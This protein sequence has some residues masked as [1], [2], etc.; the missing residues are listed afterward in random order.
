MQLLPDDQ[1]DFLDCRDK[2]CAFDKVVAK[3]AK[4]IG[5]CKVWGKWIVILEQSGSKTD[6]ILGEAG[7]VRRGEIKS[8]LI[9][10]LS[11]ASTKDLK[12]SKV[13]RQDNG[14]F[15]FCKSEGAASICDN[16]YLVET[17]AK[18]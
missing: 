10:T 12:N 5:N 18:Y 9:L 4:V 17:K 16:P 7:E 13:I 8:N 15:W 1:T 11:D 3:E 2:V 14:I 6:R